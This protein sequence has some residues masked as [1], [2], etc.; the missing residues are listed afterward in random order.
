MDEMRGL[1]WESP[2]TT[3]GR[4]IQLDLPEGMS[5][6]HGGH[7]KEIQVAY[8]SW[9][10]LNATR[11][12]AVLIIHPLASDC[13]VTGNSDDR[14][15]GW[16][17]SLVGP[18][19]AIDTDRYFVVCPNLLGGCY[20]TTGPRFPAPDG[21]PYLLRFP[22]LTPLDMMRVQRLVVRRLGIERLHL[23][24]GASMG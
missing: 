24:I 11:D 22:L 13:H 5:F 23:V 8:E 18:G 10:S 19:R 2:T 7:L 12:N 20:G 21:E 4:V 1:W 14:A 15:P 17:E 9:G 16:W 3:L 6:E